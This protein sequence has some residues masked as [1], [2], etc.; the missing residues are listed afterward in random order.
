MLQLVYRQTNTNGNTMKLLTKFVD[1]HNN[2]RGIFGDAP[3]TFPLT[4]KD[5]TNLT[6][7]IDNNLSPENLSC[8]GEMSPAM[9]RARV[10]LLNGAAAGLAKYAKASGYT[11]PKTH[12]I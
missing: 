11:Q 6:E 4:Q 2:W 5:V 3:I 12:C 10:K 8:D 9:V 7:T 1:S